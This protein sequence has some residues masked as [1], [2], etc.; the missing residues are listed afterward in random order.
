MC[1]IVTSMPGDKSTLLS[2]NYTRP[3]LDKMETKLRVNFFAKQLKLL[4]FGPRMFV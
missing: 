1:G 4:T 2:E 3:I